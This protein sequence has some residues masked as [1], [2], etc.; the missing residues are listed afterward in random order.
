MRMKINKR[1]INWNRK[2]FS[3]AETLLA[4]ALMAFVA[5]AAIGGMVVIQR[6][7]E[8]IDRQARANMIMVATVSYLRADLNCCTN[9]TTMDCSTEYVI[10][11]NDNNSYGPVFFNIDPQFNRYKYFMLHSETNGLTALI[12]GKTPRVQY[13]N[14]PQGICVG[15]KYDGFT[16]ST[17]GI[18][19]PQ[20][21]RKY[22]LGQNVMQGTGM[23]SRIG[24]DQKITYHPDEMYF[25]FTVEVVDSSGQAILSQDVIVCPDTLYPNP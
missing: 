10:D 20:A 25:T 23:N 7:K 4:V 21:N 13:W 3:L 12:Q 8:T 11:N 18:T 1:N 6:V 22:I 9:P 5:T 15:I 2:G 16:G 19:G 14:S 24:G 17:N